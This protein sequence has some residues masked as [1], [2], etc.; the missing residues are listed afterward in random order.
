MTPT[1]RVSACLLA[2]VAAA[3]SVVR[4]DFTSAMNGAMGPY[5]AALIA[6]ERGDAEST[7]RNL[8]IL[9]AR[10]D[11]VAREEP[12]AALKGDPQ[13]RAAVERVAAIIRRSQNLVRARNL[14]KT[15]I[16]LEGLRLVLRDARGRHSLLVLDDWLTDYHES[17]ERIAVRASMQNE[18]VLADADYAEMTKD[19]AR[20]ESLWTNVEREAG[21]VASAPGWADAARRI[22]AAHGELQKLLAKQDPAAVAGTAGQLKE[23]Y[24]T[25][26]V[27]L[28]RA[29]R[30]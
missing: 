26:L 30:E 27:A 20:A 2:A 24:H 4:A 17:M 23:A 28:A 9:A 1:L 16:E 19:L 18:I 10:W 12:P 7:Q 29:S 15:H 8:V 25:L 13:W 21:Q 3:L 22:T 5:Y 11:Q 6:S 14:Q